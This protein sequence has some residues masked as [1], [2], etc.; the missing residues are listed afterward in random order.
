MLLSIYT[1]CRP[2]ELVDTLKYIDRKTTSCKRLHLEVWDSIDDL[3]E[4]EC[5]D[6]REGLD[7]PN[8]QG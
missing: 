2:A 7:K 5:I 8:Y 4:D 6:N 3:D 1:G